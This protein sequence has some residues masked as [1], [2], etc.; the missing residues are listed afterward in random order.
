ML[1]NSCSYHP[2]E[3]SSETR[4]R[5]FDPALKSKNQKIAAS[6]HSTAPA[7]QR[8]RYRGLLAWIRNCRSITAKNTNFPEVFVSLECLAIDRAPFR[9]CPF[10]RGKPHE[11]YRYGAVD[12]VFTGIGRLRPGRKECP[13]TDGQSRRNRQA[14]HRRYA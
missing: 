6:F 3:L 12:H 11:T 14:G 4:L 13:A 7:E 1:V 8:D 5:S 9:T 10:S 2:Q